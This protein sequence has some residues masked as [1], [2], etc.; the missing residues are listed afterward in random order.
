MRRPSKKELKA[1]LEFDSRVCRAVR[2]LRIENF[3]ELWVSEREY[4]RHIKKRIK[5]GYI[6]DVDDY[7]DKIKEVFFHPD[8]VRWKKYNKEYKNRSN[9]FDRFYYQKE[10]LWVDIFLENGK[11]ATA[12]VMDEKDFE[13]ILLEGDLSTF[14]IIDIN[15]ED[16]RYAT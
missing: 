3:K 15:I 13:E 12:F 4:L 10:N 2:D 8:N 11:I 16:I 1:F 9:R 5:R 6:E 14:E 7:I